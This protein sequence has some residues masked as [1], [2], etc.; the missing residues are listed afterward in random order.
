MQEFDAVKAQ[1][2]ALGVRVRSV[3]CQH[4]DIPAMLARRGCE[5]DFVELVSD[6]DFSICKD[7]VAKG[8]EL[9]FAQEERDMLLT[10]LVEKDGFESKEAAKHNMVQPAICVED[11]DGNV[12][13]KW[14]WH[15]VGT[16]GQYV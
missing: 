4:G 9:I 13:Y 11:D 3:V 15:D 14:S 2:S 12:V 1:L 6:P 5:L 10:A 8:M 7:Y 16:V